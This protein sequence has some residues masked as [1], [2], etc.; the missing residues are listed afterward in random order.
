MSSGGQVLLPGRPRALPSTAGLSSL[1]LPQKA[2]QSSSF[3]GPV[4]LLLDMGPS[5]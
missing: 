1:T 2:L 5:T 4:L 3:Q